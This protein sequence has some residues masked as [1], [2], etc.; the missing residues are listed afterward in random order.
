VQ[1]KL[2]SRE[3]KLICKNIFSPCAKYVKSRGST[4]LHKTMN[5]HWCKHHGR[6]LADPIFLF[7]TT[8]PLLAATK[9]KQV[10]V[11]FI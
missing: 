4:L 11:E 3:V 8:V 2:E 9:L 10:F 7:L 1:L 5:P 6:I